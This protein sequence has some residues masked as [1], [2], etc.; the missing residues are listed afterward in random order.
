MKKASK[1]ERVNFQQPPTTREN[2]KVHLQK[3]MR[4]IE[5]KTN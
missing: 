4:A 2:Q 3:W 1:K 5:T